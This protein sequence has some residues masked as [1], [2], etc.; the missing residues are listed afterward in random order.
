MFDNYGGITVWKVSKYIISVPKGNDVIVFNTFTSSLVLLEKELY[1]KAFIDN[2][3]NDLGDDIVNS[4]TEMSYLVDAELNEEFRLETIRTRG[5]YYDSDIRMVTIAPTLAC[6]ARCYYCY[7]QGIEFKMMS[8]ETADALVDF[9]D[10]HCSKRKLTLTWFGGEPLMGKKMIDYITK[11]LLSRGI[12]ILS[13]ITTNGYLIDDEVIEK[14]KSYWNIR[15]FQIT[16][17][18]I[19]EEYNRIKAF[20]ES[21]NAFDRV[22]GNIER[23]LENSIK[24]NVRINFD[25][26]RIEGTM[27]TID[28]LQERFGKYSTF[29]MYVAAINDINVESVLNSFEDKVE[30]P[31]LTLLR[32]MKDLGFLC[33]TTLSAELETKFDD[34]E[35]LRYLNLRSRPI[36]CYATCLN[37]FVVDPDGNFYKCH[38]L[39]GRGK[40]FICGNVYEGIKFNNAYKM[41]IDGKLSSNNCDGCN[42]LPMCQGG[43][44]VK[45]MLYGE[46][47][48]CIANKTI[49]KDLVDLLAEEMM[50]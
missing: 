39:L 9:L 21:G 50:K 47:Q 4:L 11:S 12:E 44:K 14:S 27:E 10:K 26:N 31:Y 6:N 49:M 20:V 13:V 8:K 15:R 23:L 46:D 36:A 24:V 43:C 19:G 35:T 42:L 7:E 34:E 18:G 17:D 1:Q 2:N 25:P 38:R 37:K 16:I 29:F 3:F 41:F 28:Y 5:R 30:H 45:A 40:E 33:P 32:K 22:T 48:A